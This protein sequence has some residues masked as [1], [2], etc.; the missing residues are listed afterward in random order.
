MQ[1]LKPRDI[2]SVNCECSSRIESLERELAESKAMITSL[3]KELVNERQL[4]GPFT[5]ES[6]GEARD[7]T[8]K[9]YWLAQF[10]NF[11]SYL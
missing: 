7:D 6:M 11:G 2:V 8:I 5:E 3:S 10:Q 9:F 4:Q 1:Y